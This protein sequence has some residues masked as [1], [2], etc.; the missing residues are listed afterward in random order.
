MLLLNL[1]L[2]CPYGTK[3]LAELGPLDLSL[4]T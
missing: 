3:R 2:Y 1:S 4:E